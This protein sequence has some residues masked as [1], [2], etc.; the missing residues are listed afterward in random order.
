MCVC[1]CVR[2]CAYVCVCVRVRM[3]V[4]TPNDRDDNNDGVKQIPTVGHKGP[5]PRPQ[6][7]EPQFNLCI[8]VHVMILTEK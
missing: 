6:D 3:C 2:A 4:C 5:K 8:C 1:V 7:I